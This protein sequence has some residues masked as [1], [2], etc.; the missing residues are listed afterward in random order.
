MKKTGALSR[1]KNE[2]VDFKYFSKTGI[3]RRMKYVEGEIFDIRIVL[4]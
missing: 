2:I 4:K 3:W 1:K